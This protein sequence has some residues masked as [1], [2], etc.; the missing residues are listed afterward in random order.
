M[1]IFIPKGELPKEEGW[2][3]G[4]GIGALNRKI[5]PWVVLKCSDGTLGAGGLNGFYDVQAFDWFG[6]V[7]EV[8]ESGT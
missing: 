3:Y 7:P 1:T 8:R 6:P 2:Y 5:I 4:R